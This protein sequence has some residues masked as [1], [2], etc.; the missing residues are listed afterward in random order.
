MTTYLLTKWK[1]ILKKG[2]DHVT[3]LEPK[4]VY[5]NVFYHAGSSASVPLQNYHTEQHLR[6]MRN[7]Q[8]LHH[9]NIKS[10]YNDNSIIQLPL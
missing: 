3:C 8:C 1:T 7:C 2:I 10:A 5:Y 6:L 9:I 4:G